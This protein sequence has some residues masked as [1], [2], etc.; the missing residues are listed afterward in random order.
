[1][2][3]LPNDLQYFKKKTVGNTIVMGRKTFESLGRVL[4]NRKHI[5][6]TRSNESFPDEVIVV[7]NINDILRY[8]EENIDEELFVIGGGEIFKQIVP[9]VD[10]MYITLI[11]QQFDCDVYFPDIDFDR[12]NLISKEKGKKDEANNYDY[13]FL[14]YERKS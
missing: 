5:I 7:H 6:L 12:W 14:V 11:V 3:Y 10:K 1:P 8:A 9:F 13:F 2:W 4:P